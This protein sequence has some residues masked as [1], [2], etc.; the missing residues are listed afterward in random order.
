MI[1]AVIFDFDGVIID[2]EPLHFQAFNHVINPLGLHVSFEEYLAHYSGLSEN[3]VFPKL[4]SKKKISFSDS[5]TKQLIAQ[6]IAAY[7][8]IIE[9]TD[10]LPFIPG[11]Q[12]YLLK[13]KNDFQNIAIC[14]GA[15]R[16]EVM[17]VLTKLNSE[18]DDRL[19]DVIITFD[20]VKRG[21]PS[22]EGYLLAAKQLAVKPTHC[23]VFED[24]PF[25]IAAAKKA[26]M[27]VVAL[28]TT[29]NENELQNAD[30]I[31]SNFLIY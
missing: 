17:P 21:K 20:D 24:T 19:F 16:S 31:V 23:L 29:H 14:S 6:K 3:E 5:K 12:D 18:N 2:S 26:G 7:I 25:G 22:P 11:I 4:F 28:T 30:Q 10:Q 15:M 13:A 1:E 27:T 9:E 8:K